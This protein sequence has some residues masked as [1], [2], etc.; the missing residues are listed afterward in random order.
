MAAALPLMDINQFEWDIVEGK[1]TF[2]KASL[3]RL[4]I[5]LPAAGAIGYGI[6]RLSYRQN[7]VKANELMIGLLILEFIGLL[8]INAIW[9]YISL[10]T[11]P[12]LVH[13]KISSNGIET[14][15]KKISLESINYGNNDALLDKSTLSYREWHRPRPEDGKPLVLTLDSSQ[16]KIK[17]LFPEEYVRQKFIR[18]CKEYLH[19]QASADLSADQVAV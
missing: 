6:V 18:T 12:A 11:G 4:I 15:S 5:L 14:S 17:L 2:A 8:I 9:H 10:S 7:Y 16:G 1:V 13:F 3:K 19:P